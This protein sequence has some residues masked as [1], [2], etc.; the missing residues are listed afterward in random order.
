MTWVKLDDNFADHPKIVGL[1]DKAFRCYVVGLC[2]AARYLTDGFLPDPLVKSIGGNSKV[3][4]ELSPD[5]W[6]RSDSGW[7]IHDYL[8]FNPSRAQVLT[9]REQA[10]L[11]MFMKR[12]QNVRPNKNGT[13]P[14][15]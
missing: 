3:C 14:D 12:S 2:Y 7:V 15:V 4:T 5:L 6:E 11:R 8:T 10:K 1:S 9:E 13:S